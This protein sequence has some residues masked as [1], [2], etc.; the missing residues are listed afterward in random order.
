TVL[1][2]PNGLEELHMGC[3][4]NKFKERLNVPPTLRLVT[5]NDHGPSADFF[6]P[7]DLSNVMFVSL[8]HAPTYRLD[9]AGQL[10][11]GRTEF[12]LVAERGVWS[13]RRAQLSEPLTAPDLNL[14]SSMKMRQYSS[15]Y[16]L[17]F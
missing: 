7:A 6:V 14:I 9:C 12:S 13:L 1:Q 8:V 3:Y 17:R 16:T 4:P 2:L 5:F 15:E 10:C 11:A